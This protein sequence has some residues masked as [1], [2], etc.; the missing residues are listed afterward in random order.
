MKRTKNTLIAAS[1]TLAIALGCANLLDTSLHAPQAV[2]EPAHTEL[3]NA[4]LN[5][6]L[7]NVGGVKPDVIIVIPD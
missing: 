2:S 6:T 7:F 4:D 3:A 1:L 5:S